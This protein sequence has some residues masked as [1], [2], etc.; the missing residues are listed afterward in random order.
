M[1]KLF[2]MPYGGTVTVFSML[3]IVLCGYFLGT[4]RGVMAGF[5]VGLLNLILGPYIIHPV[6]VA[7]IVAEELELGADPIIAAFLHDVVEDTHYTI[8]FRLSPV[9][10]TKPTAKLG[11]K[12]KKQ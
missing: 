1:L 5:C 6:C 10:R 2:E 4:R 11:K 12:C 9:W 8:G 3:P 7:R